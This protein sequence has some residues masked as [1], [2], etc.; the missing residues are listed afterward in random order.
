MKTCRI[1]FAVP[2]RQL[3]RLYCKTRSL[4]RELK[5]QSRYSRDL[6]HALPYWY[7]FNYRVYNE[8]EARIV[9]F[10]TCE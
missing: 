9:T 7:M 4:T 5:G 8:A 3:L 10:K 6:R 1:R 2:G